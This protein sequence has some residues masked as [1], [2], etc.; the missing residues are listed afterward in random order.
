MNLRARVPFV[1]FALLLNLCAAAPARRVARAEAS[2]PR[3]RV[4]PSLKYDALCFLNV[5]TGDPFYRRFYADEYALFEPRLTPAARAALAGL[6][7]K[8]KDE[9][10]N[11]VSAFLCLYFSADG[12]ETLDGMLA[13]LS[14]A[15]RMRDALKRTPYYS[16]RGWRLFESVRGELRTALLC[17]KESGFEEYW[18]RE[19]EP[20][21]ARRSEVFA[22]ALAKYDLAGEAERRLGFMLPP[23]PFEVYVLHFARPHGSR[24]AGARLVV[25]ESYPSE[26]VLRVALHELLHPPYLLARDAELRRALGALRADEFLMTKV[27][28]HDPSFGYNSFEGFVEED[29]VRALEQLIGERLG[30]ASDAR[31]RWKEEDGGVHVLAAALYELMRREGYAAS[32]EPFRDFL[33]RALST[34]ALAPGRIKGL[35]DSFYSSLQSGACD[36]RVSQPRSIGGRR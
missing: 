15:Q 12:G 17:L 18:R 6:K 26:V 20:S 5:L 19:V 29:C 22:G 35:Y 2:P 16:D 8:L 3:W 23:G 10:G 14:R 11:V 1:L 4:S 7:R 27:R 31:R 28:G 24:L 36:S 32:A 30:V 33:L 34:R 25:D 21:A 9:N 13:A